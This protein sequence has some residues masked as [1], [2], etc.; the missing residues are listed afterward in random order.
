MK[1]EPYAAAEIEPFTDIAR[2]DAE[3][4]NAITMLH[5][6]GITS[7]SEGKLMPSNATNRG[8]AAKLFVNFAAVLK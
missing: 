7:G 6:F 2:Y 1:Q 5:A 3:T 4:Q 8:Q